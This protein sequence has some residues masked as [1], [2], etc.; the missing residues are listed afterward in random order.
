MISEELIDYIALLMKQPQ[1][2]SGVMEVLETAEKV[3]KSMQNGKKLKVAQVIYRLGMF[4]LTLSMFDNFGLTLDLL[5]YSKFD[6][7]LLRRKNQISS[8]TLLELADGLIFLL[9]KGYQIIQTKSVDCIYHSEDEYS[10]LY[11]DIEDLK[12]KKDALNNPA[13]LNFN[14][15]EYGD[16]LDRTIDK[17]QCV[18]KYAASLDKHE[19]RYWRS[20]LVDL[21]MIKNNILIAR[22]CTESREAPFAILFHATPGVGKSTLTKMTFQHLAKTHK[23]PTDD[24]FM[25]IR[26]PHAKYMDGFKSEMHTIVLD[27][28]SLKHPTKNPTGDLS[29]D[30][31]YMISGTFQYIPDQAALEDKGK[32]PV[33][34]K[35][36]LGTTNVKDL[37]AYSYYSVPGA[38]QR[39]FPYV[40]SVQVKKEFQMDD[41]SGR[42]DASKTSCS[43]D[44]YPNYWSLKVEKVVIDRRKDRQH[45]PAKYELVNIFHDINDY[46]AW[47]S[48]ISITHFENESVMTTAFRNMQNV[49]ICDKCYVAKKHCKCPHEQSGEFIDDAAYIMTETANS[50][51]PIAD[52]ALRGCAYFCALAFYYFFASLAMIVT[53]SMYRSIRDYCESKLPEGVVNYI[54]KENFKKLATKVQ[55]DM[56]YPLAFATLVSVLM[57]FYSIFRFRQT[58]TK[59]FF[60]EQTEEQFADTD[61][62]PPQPGKYERPSPWVADNKKLDTMDLTPVIIS[63]N[64]HTREDMIKRF[65]R[66]VIRLVI[67]PHDNKKQRYVNNAFFLKSNIVICN[68]H[69]LIDFNVTNFL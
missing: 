47:L 52:A 15:F 24:R 63:S 44:E 45:L 35:F 66:N 36:L 4:A 28:I 40:V 21:R 25:Y 7:E 23:L 41:G 67:R 3:V 11:D 1:E 34:I 42:L 53:G 49:E 56:G 26:N 55:K 65:S 58:A 57:I 62:R 59:N 46:T 10:K 13:A 19:V 37:N 31:V 33:R 12:L 27:D 17:L 6:Q 48:K 30:E 51:I 39:R 16:K 8:D 60:T 5:G 54:R 69:F 22:N 61:F 50:A 68:A 38:L 64:Q 18:V 2:E 32:V 9:K 29:L 20:Q 43:P 14:E